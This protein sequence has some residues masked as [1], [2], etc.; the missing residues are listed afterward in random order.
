M[1]IRIGHG[2]DIH[3]LKDGRP[4]ILG[5]IDFDTPYGLEGH[6][7]ADALT[8]AICDSRKRLHRCREGHLVELRVCVS[9]AVEHSWVFCV[10]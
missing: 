6:S 9:E 5:G 2:Y 1:K 3:P 10:V 4:M 8:H 7:D